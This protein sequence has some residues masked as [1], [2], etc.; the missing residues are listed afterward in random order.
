MRSRAHS[1][2][3]V[4][5]FL[6]GA[7]SQPAAQKTTDVHPGK[8][9]SPHVRTEW[10]IDGAKL[11]IEYGR[12][13][14][15]GRTDAQVMPPGMPWRVGA[16]EATTLVT[17]KTLTFGSLAVPPGTYNIFAQPGATEW[18]LIVSKRQK[19]W[20]IPYPAGQ[21][22][23]RAPMKAGK[24]AKPVEQLTISVDDTPTGGTLRFEWG[25]T[26]ASIPFTVS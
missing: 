3:V 19:G 18:Q 26:S 2:M 11:S 13:Y 15:K 20:G 8:G 24:T 6:M 7:V 14:M 9:G 25:S 10:S 22:F 16:D 17:D 1:A 12:P 21:D 5:A 23:G 4:A